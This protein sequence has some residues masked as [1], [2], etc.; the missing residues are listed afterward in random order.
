MTVMVQQDQKDL[1][2]STA[3]SALKNRE[4]KEKIG[5]ENIGGPMDV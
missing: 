2:L 3:H 5:E 1:F 4:G